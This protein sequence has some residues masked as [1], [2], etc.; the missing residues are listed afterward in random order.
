MSS[1]KEWERVVGAQERGQNWRPRCEGP[2]Q[3]YSMKTMGVDELA[4]GQWEE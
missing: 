3:A 2:L 1:S 4:Q